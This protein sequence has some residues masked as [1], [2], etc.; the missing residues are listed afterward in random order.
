[1][2]IPLTYVAQRAVQFVPAVLFVVTLTFALVRLAAGDPVFVLAGESGADPAYY[3]MMR[4]RLGLD[5][6]IYR[7]F[8]GYV[9]SLVQ[10][11]LGRS[12][13]NRAPVLSLIWE[14]VPATALL[15]AAAILFST[16][17]GMALGTVS[18]LKAGSAVDRAVIVA[19]LVGYATP[20][21]WLGQILI[22]VFA[23]HLGVLPVGGIQSLGGER[24]GWSHA[25]DVARHLILP[26]VSLGLGQ[27]AVVARITRSSLLNVLGQDFVR[28]ARAKGLPE[29]VVVGK[30]ASRNA[31]LPVITVV[32]A[33]VAFLAGGSVLVELIFGWPGIG[34]LL[35]DAL[36]QR[37]YP[38][39]TGVFLVVS[40]A[41]L[42]ISFV[43]DVLYAI[44]NPRITYD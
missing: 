30:H 12:H 13:I 22:L 35:Y 29:T 15:A 39:T 40:M 38:I 41:V 7:Q 31:V 17:A 16:V 26:A 42:V 36:L 6:P 25:W 27:L 34:R 44:V 24:S 32:G 8:A 14:R 4:G 9:W 28:T 10:G 21:F 19:S 23:L 1:M 33:N 37:D 43:V 11:D 2:R 3:E 18:A 20:L 5:K